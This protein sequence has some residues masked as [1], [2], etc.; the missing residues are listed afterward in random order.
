MPRSASW[1][2]RL[3]AKL[4]EYYVSD[5]RTD[6]V[7]I[8]LPRGGYHLEF[9]SAP[10]AAPAAETEARPSRSMRPKWVW[11]AAGLAG[12]V[13][14]VAAFWAGARFG[15]RSGQSLPTETR[16]IW[17]PFLQNGKSTALVMGVPVMTRIGQSCGFVCSEGEF[18]R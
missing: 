16:A 6:P 7:K 12:A 1:R 14:L 8:S 2:F 11:G 9:H 15:S 5:G 18:K 4:A 13:L 3:R 17:G 10:K